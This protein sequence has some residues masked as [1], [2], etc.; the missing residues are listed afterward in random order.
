MHWVAAV[1]LSVVEPGWPRLWTLE[2][3]LMRVRWLLL[4]VV[5]LV[6]LAA[7]SSPS[8]GPPEPASGAVASPSSSASSEWRELPPP[9]EY[10][11]VSV[12]VDAR[13]QAVRD[14]V[15]PDELAVF[16][17]DPDL[18]VRA[19]VAENSAA[20]VE[21]LSLLV[22]DPDPSVRAAA[23]ASGRLPVSVLPVMLSDPSR[24]VRA[25][26]GSSAPLEWLEARAASLPPEALEASLSRD[27]VSPL[28]LRQAFAS[29]D[30]DLQCAVVWHLEP[31]SELW[32]A[33]AS[34]LVDVAGSELYCRSWA[35]EFLERWR[36]AFEGCVSS[37]DRSL[38]EFEDADAYTSALRDECGAPPPP[39]PSGL[40]LPAVLLRGDFVPV[41][42]S[43]VECR[44]G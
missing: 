12:P 42:A 18:L 19:A 15:D 3:I 1:G 44:L 32:P 22:R 25:A 41:D 31:R 23:V 5:L 35:V 24:A 33:F 26:V 9:S 34:E 39:L 30:E 37:F 8:S 43:S 11:W 2:V 13:L 16:V 38:F 27:D 4:L 7:C 17:D 40:A 36:S 14:A 6:P 10:E 20:S 21:L 28:L 29:A